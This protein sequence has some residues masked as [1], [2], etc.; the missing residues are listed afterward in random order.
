MTMNYCGRC[1]AANGTAAR[2]CRQCGVELHNQAAFSSTSSPL[3]VEFSAH[4]ASKERPR[5]ETPASKPAPPTPPPF[6][7]A[8]PT[9]SGRDKGESNNPKAIS[10][11]LKKLRASG[12]LI[13]E[14]VKKKQEQLNQIISESISGVVEKKPDAENKSGRQAD[15]QAAK[16]SEKQSGSPAA[17]VTAELAPQ[18]KAKTTGSL[19]APTG[20]VSVMP[21]ASSANRKN[22]MPLPPAS[23]R[24]TGN[25]SASGQLPPHGPSSVLAQASGLSKQS[26]FGSKVRIGLIAALVVLLAGGYFLLRD[27]WSGAIRPVDAGR[28]LLSAEE[29]SADFVRLGQRDRE[30]GHYDDAIA[31]FANALTL[32]P[33]NPDIHFYLAQTYNSAGQTDEALKNYQALL[34]VAPD[35]LEA[36]LQV[37]EI[38]RGRGSWNQALQEYQRI[39][40]LDQNSP[41]AAVALAAMESQGTPETETA[42]VKLPRPRATSKKTPVALPN[43]VAEV[44][45]PLLTPGLSAAPNIKPP[46]APSKRPEESPDPRAAA[47][48][49]KKLGLRYFNVRE[50]HAAIKEFLSALRLTPEDKDIYYF[51]GSSYYGLGQQALAHDYYKRVDSGNYMG[52]AQSG[53]ARTEKAARE[54]FKR[55]ELL[56]NDSQNQ[57]RNDADRKGKNSL[58]NSLE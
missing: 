55:R 49:H 39:I 36:R 50:Y 19:K 40:A 57:V 10:E 58:N 41:Q 38:Y 33:K 5:E 28:N 7:T 30:Q 54:E 32:T 12:P 9:T 44:K 56:K 3:N 37:A 25:L 15:Q 51:L 2:F 22:S 16:Q 6:P 23:V 21:N 11:S 46:A 47:D 4:S 52:V 26:N 1:G 14:A 42:E 24:G 34:R 43:A 48:G 31:Y 8:T 13:T 18:P 20:A 35:Y 53:A 17:P 45:L 29:K 27:R